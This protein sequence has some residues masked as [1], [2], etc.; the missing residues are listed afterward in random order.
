M[1][2]LGYGISLKMALENTKF[3]FIKKIFEHYHLIQNFP[4][5]PEM[6]SKIQ[7]AHFPLDY[8]IFS[9]IV[10]WIFENISP[11]FLRVSISHRKTYS[12]KYWTRCPSVCQSDIGIC[13]P[14]LNHSRVGV[15]FRL[16]LLQ[17]TFSQSYISSESPGSRLVCFLD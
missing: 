7:S 1:S 4:P 11:G 9:K 2:L 8:S 10:Q 16:I 3:E 15:T 13:N 17:V 14:L 12:L 5:V 6:I